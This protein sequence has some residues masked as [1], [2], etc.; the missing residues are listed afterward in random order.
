[1]KIVYTYRVVCQ[2]LSAPELGP[3]ITYGILAARD[4]RGC[5]Q[6]VQFI[7]DVSLDRALVEAT[8]TPLHRRP[9]RPLPP[10]GRGR[11]CHQ[12]VKPSAPKGSDQGRGAPFC[13][14]SYSARDTSHMLF[15]ASAV[16]AR[17]CL[18]CAFL[19]GH[20]N[21]VVSSCSYSGVSKN[22]IRG[23]LNM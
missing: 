12:R 7:S 1:M 21:L 2:K 22:H 11:G 8:R 15:P 4:L 17:V 13:R 19:C 10:A 6:V 23:L 5:Q 14:V 18:P 9:A 16:L 3:Y 20:R